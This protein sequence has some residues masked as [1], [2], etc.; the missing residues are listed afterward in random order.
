MS[1]DNKVVWTEGMFLRTQ[2]FQQADRYAE[3]LVRGAVGSLRG[4]GWGL[5][6]LQIN[7][8]LLSTG[9]FAI[10]RCSGVLEDGTPF[11]VPDDADHPP[12][13]ELPENCRNCIVYLT[14]P[15]RQPGGIEFD[16]AGQEETVARY[17]IHEYEARDAAAGSETSALLSIGKLRLRFGLE[18]DELAGYTT[19][20]LARVVEVR[21]DKNVVLDEAYIPPMLDCAASPVLSGFIAELQGLFHHRGQALGGRV[22]QAGTKG[23]SEFADFLLLQAVNRYEPLLSHLLSAA[24]VHPEDLY[25]NCVQMAGE[26]A[27]FT[28]TGKRPPAF[29]SYRHEDLQATFRPVMAELR[30]SLSAV[31][32]QTAIPIPLQERRFGIRVAQ[33]ADRSLLTQ[34]TFVLTVKAE[35]QADGVRR[36]F[37]S[38]AKL[39]PVEQIRELVNV[40]L[41]GIKLRPLP[42]APRQ[43]PFNSGATYFELERNSPFWKQ[44]GQSGGLAIHVAGNF[45]Q[46]EMELW[47]IRG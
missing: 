30:Q 39:G 10:S 26:L 11:V 29:P 9:R 31:L 47:A 35:M 24:N 16:S 13:V 2:H 17:G 38:Q 45:P 18:T 7:R 41:P 8:E 21:A 32:E 19:L 34:A 46:L 1:T 3:R 25:A 28:A 6:E 4:Y 22:A 37:P 15:V 5:T 14:L 40:A 42:V 36:H 20:G 33:I 23:T 44:L 27:T 12:P 43:M